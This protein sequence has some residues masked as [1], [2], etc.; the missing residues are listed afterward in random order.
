MA[1]R[2]GVAAFV[3]KSTL[4]RLIAASMA[5][6]SLYCE[7]ACAGVNTLTQIPMNQ[8]GVNKVVYE[9]GN[10]TRA[11]AVASSG[12]YRSTDSGAT[13]SLV[14]A[15]TSNPLTDIAVNPALP[16]KAFA[17]GG[18]DG[19]YS[20]SNSG[21]SFALTFVPQFET[22]AHRVAIS[23]DGSRIYF[24]TNEHF[25]SSSDG[26][27][28]WSTGAARSFAGLT[29]LAVDPS[30]ASHL[31]AAVVDTQVIGLESTDAGAT[32]HGWTLPAQP[33]LV[34]ELVV[35]NSQP[36]RI[37]AAAYGGT[38]YSTDAGAH[39][40]R[41]GSATEFEVITV[42]P[43]NS[44]VIYAGGASRLLKSID[45]GATWND[46]QGTAQVGNITSI[47]V[48]PVHPSRILV[49]GREGIIR[50]SDGG[51]AWVQSNSGIESLYVSQLIGMPASGRI[52]VNGGYGVFAVDAASNAVFSLNRDQL[53]P[54]TT[55]NTLDTSG[56][57]VSRSNGSDHLFV[58]L[59]DTIA[60]STDAGQSWKRIAIGGFKEYPVFNIFAGSADQRTLIGVAYDAIYRS[61]NGGDSWSLVQQ[62]DG[63]TLSARGVG[64]KSNPAVAYL[65]AFVGSDGKILKSTDA[66]AHWSLL[67]NTPPEIY[68]L[69]VDPSDDRVV[70][71]AGIGVV[72]KSVDGGASWS[73]SRVLAQDDSINV[74][75][76]DPENHDAVYAASGSFVARSIDGG[77]HWQ[78]LLSPGSNFDVNALTVD[79]LQSGH[80]YVGTS[81]RGLREFSVEPDLEV[82]LAPMPF[83]AVGTS[84][85]Y[86]VSV[87]NRGPFDATNARVSLQLP[88]GSTSIVPTP[89]SGTCAVQ[90]VSVHCNWPTLKESST[91]SV[92]IVA[93]ESVIE[94][95]NVYANVVAD[96]ADSD[97]SN[98]WASV[99]LRVVEESELSL[100]VDAP[101]SA[102]PASVVQYVLTAS[103]AG[104]ND[105][106]NVWVDF[107]VNPDFGDVKASS[108][109][110]TCTVASNYVHCIV[111]L[112]ELNAASTVTVNALTS[113]NEG[114]YMS[115]GSVSAV[116]GDDPSLANNMYSGWIQVAS[117][118]ATS[119]PSTPPSVDPTPSPSPPSNPDP[120]PSPSD[121]GTTPTPPSQ[122]PSVPVA[123]G[124]TSSGAKGGGGGGSTSLEMLA[125]LSLI[126]FTKRL[127]ARRQRGTRAATEGRIHVKR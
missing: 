116:S 70:Y 80:I 111:P 125:M 13:W 65:G 50:S 32:W 23:S 60:R 90:G 119:N 110:G 20:T 66:G 73:S 21:A 45:N 36:Q 76:V 85:T 28:H 15:N 67:N 108:P 27:A 89:T 34:N 78:Q 9:P 117:P 41:S 25:Y 74:L 52:Y 96:E 55:L 97:A 7:L 64:S 48:D 16:G 71:A 75:A 123:T 126:G 127:C 104:R 12:I 61:I 35:V 49:S 24:G 59:R 124:G 118:P 29:A 46:I 81:G 113:A 38:F 42:D 26:G 56:V 98:N 88:P 103:N 22:T 14:N 68:A 106:H 122:T 79:P 91:A 94:E 53:R 101:T 109:D 83:I 99:V 112:I 62:A 69:D 31:Y 115:S 43:T 5:I 6:T 58:G 33:G 54:W 84:A 11:Y 107:A 95:T 3:Q 120:T 8:G 102:L 86:K 63:Y 93:D 77:V 30:N 114:S 37:W 82:S 18:G 100:K 105:A 51:A 2:F 17:T 10:P 121:P 87:K 57:Y 72:R 1:S 39:W 19:I 4:K 47:S 92:A 44:S 40:T